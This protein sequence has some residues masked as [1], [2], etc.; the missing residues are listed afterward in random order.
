MQS[1][2]DCQQGTDDRLCLRH[3]MRGQLAPVSCLLQGFDRSRLDGNT[4][5]GLLRLLVTEP[6][7]FVSV[8]DEATSSL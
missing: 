6:R 5:K 8:K 2:H 3:T 7:I 1:G 4:P